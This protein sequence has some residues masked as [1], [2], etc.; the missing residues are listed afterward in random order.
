MSATIYIALLD[1]GTDVWR[2]V[3]AERVRDEIYRVTGTP[4]DD[5]ETWQFT[6]GDTVRCREQSFA[7]GERRLVAYERVTD[8][9]A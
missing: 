8:K 5:T 9:A 2:P 4:P 6:T 1:E 7:S 3:S